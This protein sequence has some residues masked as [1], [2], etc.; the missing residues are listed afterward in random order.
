MFFLL[1]LNLYLANVHIEKNTDKEIRTLLDEFSKN[2]IYS[3]GRYGAWTYCSMED[4][5]VQAK[6]LH[7]KLT[8]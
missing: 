2:N 7:D 1:S 6:E 4:A 8:N 3:I 5:M